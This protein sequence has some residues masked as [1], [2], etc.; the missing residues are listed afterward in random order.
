MS[1]PESPSPR[2]DQLLEEAAS[3]FARMRGPDAEAS[4]DAFE[5]WLRRGALH[6]AAYNRASEIF[7]MGKFL[8]EDGP[9]RPVSPQGRGGDVRQRRRWAAVAAGLLVFAAGLL[10]LQLLGAGPVKMAEDHRGAPSAP[11]SL[12][13]AAGE[14]KSVRLADGSVLTL[15]GDT[16]LDVELGQAVR[17]L[18]LMRGRALVEV[19]HEARPFMVDIGGGRVIAR[20]TVFE[21]ALGRD[22]Q[23]TVRLISGAVDVTIPGRAPNRPS[24][25]T[26]R[27]RPGESVAYGAVGDEAAAPATGA[28][29]TA[30][31]PLAPEASIDHQDI[32]VATLVEA[33]NRGSRR[34]IRL[35]D[36]AI[37]RQRVSGRFRTDDT[38]VLAER[39]ALLFDLRVEAGPDEIVLRRR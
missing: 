34:P 38:L 12:T 14:I 29:A 23:V 20:G 3:W 1:E 19:F 28:T 8:D 10:A 11:D 25:V 17:H 21:V 7:A 37:D 16:A 5:A 26:R 2:R 36:S 33:A 39:I 13:T 31:V 27:L 30:P 22:R 4:R 24:P 6:R 18:R 32:D 9:V 15:E 35:A